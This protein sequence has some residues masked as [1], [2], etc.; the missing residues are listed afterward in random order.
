MDVWSLEEFQ[1]LLTISNLDVERGVALYNKFG[2]SP[3]VVVDILRQGTTEERYFHEIET[4]ATILARQFLVMFCN[5]ENLDF[6]SGPLSKIFTVRPKSSNREIAVLFIP[7]PVVA[8]A[9]GMAFFFWSEPSK[10][11]SFACSKAIH[12]FAAPWDGSSRVT[13]TPAALIVPH[14]KHTAPTMTQT[15]SSFLIRKQ[16]PPCSRPSNHLTVSTGDLENPI[17]LAL[18]L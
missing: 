7:T 16:A 14:C 3:R 11:P 1:T 17:S 8:S 2:P 18:M 13:P 12:L 5:A 9:F 10:M 4:G 6:S 15:R